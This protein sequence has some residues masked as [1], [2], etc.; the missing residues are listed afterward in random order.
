MQLR[1][2]LTIVLLL[3]SCAPDRADDSRGD[4]EPDDPKAHREVVAASTPLVAELLEM[5]GAHTCA[6]VMVL[7]P[8]N[9]SPH[10]TEPTP[11]AV[12]A[13]GDATLLARVGLGFEH[14]DDVGAREV[15]DLAPM[16][17]PVQ[18]PWGTD[19]HFWQ[20]PQRTRRAVESL[21]R[22]LSNLEACDPDQITETTSRSAEL[23]DELDGWAT[24]RFRTIPREKRRV[25]TFHDS[26]RTM[27]ERF[28]IEVVATVVPS[29]AHE[30]EVPPRHLR[31]VAEALRSTPP[32][33]MVLEPFDE[34]ESGDLVDTLAGES[35]V[36]FRTVTILMDNLPDRSAEPDDPGL[37]YVVWFR[38]NVEKLVDAWR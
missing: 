30:A 12:S 8:A 16:V 4:A 35:G 24:E 3:A 21:S 38:E 7:L 17:D 29:T 2:I 15:V 6:D 25:V 20:D 9:A 23:L 1:M 19:P 31:T 11:R 18:G 5:A 33:I 22:R 14:L 27:A 26:L 13:A 34:H 28:D 32:P 36:E 10:E 37:D